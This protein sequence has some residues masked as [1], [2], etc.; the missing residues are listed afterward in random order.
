MSKHSRSKVRNGRK[1]KSIKILI[2]LILILVLIYINKI[3]LVKQTI[4]AFSPIPIQNIE[5][6]M[7]QNEIELGE[8]LDIETKIYPEDYSKSNLEWHSSNEDI[9]Q[10][11]DGKVIGKST[12]KASIY[13]SDNETK[14]NE[15]E[16]ECLVKMQDITIDNLVTELK[17]GDIYQLNA[18]II[19]EETTH[20]EIVYESSNIEVIQADTN[21]NLIANGIGTSTI[22]VKNY[23]NEIIK[24][25]DIEVKKIPVEEIILDD[26]KVKLGKGQ[27]YI[28][29]A[30]VSPLEATYTDVDWKSTDENIITIEDR[31]ITAVG[32][33]NA[34]II[35]TTD[36]GDKQVECSFEILKNNPNNEKKFANGNYNIRSGN[37]TDYSILATTTKYEEIEFLQDSKDGWKKVRNS[38]GI[39]GYTQIKQGYYL[40]EKPAITTDN[41]GG[42]TDN[43]V[44]SYH[45][46]NVPYLNQISLGYPTG[47]EA[48]SAT[49][50][51][52]YKG[53]N[54]SVK[55]IVDNT[56]CGSKKYQENGNWYGAN[57]FEEFVGHPTG[58]L[59][60]GNY[61]VFAKPIT[62]AMN[63]YAGGKAKNISGCSENTLLKY[64]SNGNPVV[65]WCVKNAGNLSN[66][67]NWNYTN[68]SGTF[69]ELVG[70]HCA[71]LIGYDENYV[72]LNDP[73]AG[74]NVKQ[75]R[76]KFFSNWKKLYS[77]AIIVE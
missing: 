6:S 67:V 62:D 20:K 68:G 13:L 47:C 8:E 60:K 34:S 26:T 31:K 58:G 10:V 7:T 57:P 29:N 38:K 37:S 69:Q 49:M 18:T 23:K 1:N 24:T 35:A 64:V 25:F 36:N 52:K 66:G 19:P 48:V 53:Y 33:G 44:T 4:L 12:G 16:V 63:V 70:E 39:V 72:Y 14:S 65:V 54:V 71:V 11:I 9:I 3:G 59:S 51:L 5:I 15:I 40:K 50:L 27:T 45:I 56:K 2:A 22:N 30:K 61:G 46:N 42:T 77:Q 17:L 43:I 55:N 28:I 73:S 74:E 41:D 21:G 75:S 76:S 32:I